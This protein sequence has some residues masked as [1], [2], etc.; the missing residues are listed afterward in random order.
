MG[1]S[2]GSWGEGKDLT[3]VIFLEVTWLSHINQ[4]GLPSLSLRCLDENQDW[5]PTD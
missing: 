3:V 2:Q 5:V 4:G 1:N